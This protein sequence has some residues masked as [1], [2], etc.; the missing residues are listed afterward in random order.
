MNLR[1]EYGAID[2]EPVEISSDW[3]QITYEEIR[4]EH[5]EPVAIFQD[6]FWVCGGHGKFSDIVLFSED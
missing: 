2:K 6:G 4:N 1:F 3:F 5:D